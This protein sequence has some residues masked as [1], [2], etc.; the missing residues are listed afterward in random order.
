[1]AKRGRKPRRVVKAF[2]C[3]KNNYYDVE[4][5]GT[6]KGVWSEDKVE[7]F[8]KFNPQYEIEW[9]KTKPES[10]EKP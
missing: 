2:E 6:Y 9:I 4:I 5:D 1:M 8:L 7:A 3:S 10:N